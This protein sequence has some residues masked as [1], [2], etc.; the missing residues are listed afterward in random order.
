[1]I[2]SCKINRCLLKKI[3]IVEAVDAILLHS[4][5]AN[6]LLNRKR[7]T[8]AMLFE[9][10]NA[11]R[12][13]ISGQADKSTVISKILELWSTAPQEET[14]AP[15]QSTYSVVE[16]V[17]PHPQYQATVAVD[18]LQSHFSSVENVIPSTSETPEMGLKFAQWF[19]E[20]LLA[21]HR[22]TLTGT[23][24]SDQFWKD[25][26]MKVTMNSSDSVNCQEALGSEEVNINNNF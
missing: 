13:P 6:W 20:I 3:L 10:L 25:V 5:S 18:T 12:V 9:Y 26:R 14:W 16:H 11:K 1:M 19:Y 23:K 15:S 24:L 8:R 22:Q 2:G 17:V 4:E 21:V 7:L